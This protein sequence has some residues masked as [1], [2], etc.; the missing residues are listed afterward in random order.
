[1]GETN[2]ATIR[3]EMAYRMSFNMFCAL[4]RAVDCALQDPSDE[5][6]CNMLALI[7]DCGA[8]AGDLLSILE[9]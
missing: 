3:P 2:M 4:Q 8:L 6:T 7:K 9:D 1:M 5:S